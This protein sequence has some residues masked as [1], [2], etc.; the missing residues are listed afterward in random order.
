MPVST[1]LLKSEAQHQ[2]FHVMTDCRPLARL[3][4]GAILFVDLLDP[5]KWPR[6]LDTEGNC[7]N[8][9]NYFDLTR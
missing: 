3:D 7:A 4:D 2:F 1:V 5:Y 8:F 6:L 9:W